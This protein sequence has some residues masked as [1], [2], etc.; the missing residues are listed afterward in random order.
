MYLRS[1]IIEN[2]KSFRGRHR[3]N[4]KPGVNFFVGDNNSGK[5]TVL[6][7]LLF[8]FEGPSAT[9]WTPDKF[10]C[11]ESDGATRVEVDISGDVDGL[12]A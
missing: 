12:V 8:M 10:Y 5:S 9:R 1:V 3:F 4:F 2:V 6:E 11:A 7:A